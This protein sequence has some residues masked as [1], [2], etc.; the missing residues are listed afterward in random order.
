MGS[1]LIICRHVCLINLFY[2][3]IGRVILGPMVIFN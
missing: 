3:G 2:Q 1:Q